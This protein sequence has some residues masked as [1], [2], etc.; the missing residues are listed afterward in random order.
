MHLETTNLESDHQ[1][2]FASGDYFWSQ[3]SI[4]QLVFSG[5]RE[6][7]S[8]RLLIAALPLP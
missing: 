3:L 8:D 5:M 4:N 1:I 2:T 6:Y 7:P